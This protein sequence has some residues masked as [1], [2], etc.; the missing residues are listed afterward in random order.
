MFRDAALGAS[1]WHWIGIAGS[2]RELRQCRRLLPGTPQVDLVEREPDVVAGEVAFTEVATDTEWPFAVW[3]G[4]LIV[5]LVRGVRRAAMGTGDWSQRKSPS[6][7]Y[8][9]IEFLTKL[10]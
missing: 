3:A 4:A 6:A 8:A 1:S 7:G 10:R 2:G 5:A 9:A